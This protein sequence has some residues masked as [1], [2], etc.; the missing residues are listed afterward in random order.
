MKTLLLTMILLSSCTP[1]EEKGKLTFRDLKQEEVDELQRRQEAIRQAEAAKVEFE[2]EKKRVMNEIISD[3]NRGLEEIKPLIQKKCFDCHDSNTKLPYYAHV[4]PGINPILKHQVEGI[5]ALDFVN[6]YPLKALGNPPQISLLKSIKNEVLERSMPLKSYTLV[7][8]SKR[9]FD[10]DEEKIINWVDPIITRLEEYTAK[11]ESTSSDPKKEAL[12]ILETKCFR[13]HANGVA[14]GGFGEMEDTQKL[15][16]SEY[17]NLKRPELSEIYKL[18]ENGEM[19]TNKRDKLSDHEL[20]T[21][22]EWL[23][24]ESQN[25]P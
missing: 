9:I 3:A 13:C 25:N 10:E 17:V 12:K 2:K 23:I 4:F 16:N 6:G 7:Y 1:F 21:L 5:K 22:K 18:S 15:L 11:Y 14:K 19:P 24:I 8:R 20:F